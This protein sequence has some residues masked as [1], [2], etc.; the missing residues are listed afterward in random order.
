M[1]SSLPVCLS[2]SLYRDM[3]FLQIKRLD[4][5]NE[6]F[7]TSNQIFRRRPFNLEV[8]AARHRSH[9]IQR[10]V[11]YLRPDFLELLDRDQLRP[12]RYPFLLNAREKNRTQPRISDDM[13]GTGR[14]PQN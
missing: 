10:R 5:R 14:I 1:S 8:I 6:T 4:R 11:T 3:R 7:T 13:I 12:V 9:R 2:L